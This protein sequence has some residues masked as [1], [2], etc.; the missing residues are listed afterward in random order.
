[1]SP[2]ERGAVDGAPWRRNERVSVAGGRRFAACREAL[3]VAAAGRA[4]HLLDAAPGSVAVSQM[5]L[6][7][8]VTGTDGQTQLLVNVTAV[9]AIAGVIFLIAFLMGLRCG[10]MPRR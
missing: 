5:R 4:A 9:V 3:R 2:D 10:R 1:M 8:L 6:G 7:T